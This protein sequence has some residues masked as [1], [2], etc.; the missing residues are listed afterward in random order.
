MKRCSAARPRCG[1]DASS[2]VRNYSLTEAWR[3]HYKSTGRLRLE[4]AL[5]C[6]AIV[7]QIESNCDRCGLRGFFVYVTS[8]V[9]AGAICSFSLC[10][11]LA[12]PRTVQVKSRISPQIHRAGRQAGA[13]KPVRRAGWE[14]GCATNW[15]KGDEIEE[16]AH[17]QSSL[18]GTKR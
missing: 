5:V 15:S 1:V 6:V 4:W 10:T 9:A 18:S 7:A 11:P 17:S 13:I 8:P 12:V 14:W 16:L 2:Q 3:G